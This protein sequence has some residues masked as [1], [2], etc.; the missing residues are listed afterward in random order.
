RVFRELIEHRLD[1][2]LRSLEFADRV[3]G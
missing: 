2:R 1:V 3:G